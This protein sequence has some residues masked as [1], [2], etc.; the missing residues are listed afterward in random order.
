MQHTK[1]Q[2]L[3]KVFFSAGALERD[4]LAYCLSWTL[5]KYL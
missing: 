5:S 4:E 3:Y 2:K 1:N